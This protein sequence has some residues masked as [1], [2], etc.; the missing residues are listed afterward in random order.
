MVDTSN[1]H[2]TAITA[3]TNNISTNTT[4]VSNLVDISAAHFTAI[5]ANATAVSNLVDTSNAHFT[6]ITANTSNISTNTT[7]VSNLVDISAAHFTAIT[8][9][10]NNISTNTTGISNLVDISA[11]HFTAINSNATAISNLV[12]T[13]NAHF[14]II[15]NKVNKNGDADLSSVDISLLKINTSY[16]FPTATGSAGQVLKVASDTTKLEFANESGGGGG[17][18]KIYF[19]GEKTS[20]SSA[21][22]DNVSGQLTG[23]NTNLSRSATSVFDGDTFTAPSDCIMRF[24]IGFTVEA[25]GGEARFNYLSEF[26]QKGSTKLG[27]E[28]IAYLNSALSSPLGDPQFINSTRTLTMKFSTNDTL[29]FYVNGDGAGGAGWKY[30]A[31]GTSYTEDNNSPTITS[32]ALSYFSGLQID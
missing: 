26:F 32:N 31:Y 7:A 9:N 23:C 19:Y 25:T 4:A 28:P 10:T 14:L 24:D 18:S 16:E 21:F 22:G 13:S 1:A 17:G 11:A 12:D 20:D 8:A 30:L 27:V 29:K 5:N 6:A 3:N 2:F 15:N